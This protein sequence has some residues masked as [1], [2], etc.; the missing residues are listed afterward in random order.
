MAPLTPTPDPDP[1]VALLEDLP[2]IGADEPLMFRCG[3]DVPCF[4]VCCADLTLAM[5]P[6]DVLRLRRALG[7]DS[8]KFLN[9]H[10][11]VASRSAAG[12]PSVWLRMLDE[13][14][15][16][17]PFVTPAGCGVY[18]DRPAP[19]RAYPVAR[20]AEITDAG[21]IEERFYLVREAHC[22]GFGLGEVG[23]VL[24]WVSAQGLDVY[25]EHSDRWL[26]VVHRWGRALNRTAWERT[27]SWLYQVDLLRAEFVRHTPGLLLEKSGPERERILSDD[28]ACLEFAY[29]WAEWERGRNGPGERSG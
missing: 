25:N 12:F 10:A 3:P 13:P 29:E 23:T 16:R 6:Y 2:R 27:L 7:I 8:R 24:E 9:D 26:R 5:T 22:E 28:L 1:G 21:E 4:N 14:E 17:C 19:C 20:V 11:E 15:K 18:G